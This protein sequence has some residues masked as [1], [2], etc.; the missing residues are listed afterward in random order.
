MRLSFKA[1]QVGSVEAL[2]VLAIDYP[3]VVAA[4]EK[5]DCEVAGPTYRGFHSILI[6]I[7]ISCEMGATVPT[8]GKL[9]KTSKSYRIGGMRFLR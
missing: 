8:D 3:E 7:A 9:N 4:L 1:L 5:L 2:L 6:S